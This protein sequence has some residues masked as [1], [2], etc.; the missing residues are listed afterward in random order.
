M[1]AFLGALLSLCLVSVIETASN[2][3]CAWMLKDINKAK[4]YRKSSNEIQA[5]RPKR[6]QTSAC[7]CSDI[8]LLDHFTGLAA[9]NCLVKDEDFYCY[10][11]H[12]SQCPDRRESS[13]KSGL[14]FSYQACQYK[15]G[16]NG[17]ETDGH[18]RR[19]QGGYSLLRGGGS[20]PVFPLRTLA[21]P[22]Y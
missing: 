18:T 6:F 10:V 19:G 13:R 22:L 2:N 1:K 16:V 17:E 8:T 5:L 7:L 9:G 15:T 20:T 11:A 4:K 14:Y 12:D 21:V 3:N